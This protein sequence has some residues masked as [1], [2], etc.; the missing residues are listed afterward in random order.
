MT[1]D[2]RAVHGDLCPVIDRQRAIPNE[3]FGEYRIF[4]TAERRKYNLRTSGPRIRD[5]YLCTRM[6]SGILVRGRTL[7]VPD[8]FPFAAHHFLI[9]FVG[10]AHTES[11]IAPFVRTRIAAAVQE[12]REQLTA[13][14]IDR[15]LTL[16]CE[17]G[18][19]VC[20]SMRGSGASVPDHIHAHAFARDV[21]GALS[22]PWLKPGS[23][24]LTYQ[25]AD[26]SLYRALTP[27]YGVLIE[28]KQ[29]D[30]GARVV[31]TSEILGLP[32]NL[33]VGYGE[34][35]RD[36]WVFVF[37]RTRESPRHPLFCHPATGTWKFGFSEMLGLFEFK[38]E[39]QFLG[40]TEE[41]LA[42]ALLETTIA[43]EVMRERVERLLRDP[44]ARS[45]PHHPWRR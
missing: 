41:I 32:Y 15:C 2:Y 36:Y 5:C 25:S 4:Q 29:P 43:D 7:V 20:E 24:G 42:Q 3:P 35:F 37:W 9:R 34:P 39:A 22:L 26:I 30:A 11:I 13:D 27:A 45:G 38:S 28:T 8:P 6:A 14:D 18:F 31:Y 40:L 33:I 10:D 1:E 23:V 19:L 12:H 21:P 17:T 44:P 16:A